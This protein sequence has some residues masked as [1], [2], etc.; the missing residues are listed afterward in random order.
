MRRYL[1]VSLFLLILLAP[2]ALRGTVASRSRASA[3][4]TVV[5]IT[6]HSESIRTEFA[7]AFSRWHQ[8]HFGQPAFV[9]YRIYGG[10]NDIVPYFESAPRTLYATPETY[11]IHVACGGGE[12]LFGQPAKQDS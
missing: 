3:G 8:E 7:D 9:D 1:W 4:Q 12:C 6:P 5:V 2:L 11:N 10:A